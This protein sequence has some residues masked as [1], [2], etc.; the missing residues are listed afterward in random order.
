MYA[1]FPKEISDVEVYYN[2]IFNNG[3]PEIEW[4]DIEINR[5]PVSIE[6]HELLIREY[7][8]AWEYEIINRLKAR[9]AA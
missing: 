2:I 4:E 8:E 5:H 3:E 7:G 9:A 1:F 6:L